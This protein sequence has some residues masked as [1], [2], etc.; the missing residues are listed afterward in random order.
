MATIAYPA[1]QDSVRK[2]RR[3]DGHA[4]LLD[5][6]ARQE[7][8][9]TENN[10]Y[11]S[12]LTQLGFDADTDVASPEGWYTVAATQCPAPNAGL[13]NCVLLTATPQGAQNDDTICGALTYNSLGVK[14][15]NGTGT[16]DNCW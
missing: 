1:Y 3:S 12:Q 15:E 6:M 8:F 5:V 10:T 11:T 14:E 16:V 4:F 9:Y 7:R 2:A 13:T